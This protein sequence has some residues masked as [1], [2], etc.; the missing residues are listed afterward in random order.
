MVAA[1]LC[2]APSDRDGFVIVPSLKGLVF[3]SNQQD[4]RKGGVIC[5]GISLVK[6]P[7]LNRMDFYDELPGYL[8]KPLTFKA[9]TEITSKVSAFY[10][11]KFPDATVTSCDAGRCTI[12]SNDHGRILT[13]NIDSEGDK[14][15]IQI[16]NVSHK[17]DAE[18]SSS[19]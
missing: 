17:S 1:T 5:D 6:V 15:K 18:N 11:Q 2:G 7:M 8:K 16:T 4:I 10:K 3:V 9:L 13:I 12:V 19:H 14:T